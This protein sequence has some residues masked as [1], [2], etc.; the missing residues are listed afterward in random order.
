MSTD[1][2]IKASIPGADVISAPP[3]FLT[4]DIN[5]PILKCDLR[6][7]PKNYGI[8]NFTIASIVNLTT[9]VILYQQPHGYSYLP[10]FLVAWNFPTGTDGTHP[11]SST[12]GTGDLDGLGT[13]TSSVYIA[14]FV[15]STNF[16]IMITHKAGILTNVTGSIRF[17]IFA[18][19]FSG[20]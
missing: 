17:Y 18:D 6:V 1:F 4:L 12:Y 11:D 9:P 10:G 13:F 8:V 5:Y 19:D 16:Y 14:S 20:N 2:G 7:N 3:L 15:D